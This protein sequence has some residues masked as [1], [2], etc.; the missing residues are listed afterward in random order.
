VP[1]PGKAR[2]A[3][4]LTSGLAS[5][6]LVHTARP[7][8]VGEIDHDGNK[9]L[10]EAQSRPTFRLR[11]GQLPAARVQQPEVEM[12]LRPLGGDHL[13]GDE[14]VVALT[15]AVCCCGVSD[16]RSV[17]ANARAASMA[18][19]L[20]KAM[21]IDPGN[22]EIKHSLG[23][24]LVRQ[25][26]YPG[27]L[28]LLRQASELAPDNAR[29]AYVYAI[30]LNSTGAQSKAMVL[31][32]WT[33]QRHPT[34]REVLMALIAIAQSAGDVATAL[35]LPARWPRFTLL[36]RSFASWSRI[37]K[38]ARVTSGFSICCLSRGE[39]SREHEV[40]NWH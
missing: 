39:A 26:D 30:A 9:S 21:S 12:R 17:P 19:M 27:A 34:D 33:H 38:S 20:R 16:S 25:H 40:R 37:S 23:L 8:E 24:F 31:L 22:A 35:R 14:F 3:A 1:E 11:L 6:L 10:V 2:G 7:I 29:Y 18:E 15:K 13:G 28:D 5:T 4:A 36:T 32:E